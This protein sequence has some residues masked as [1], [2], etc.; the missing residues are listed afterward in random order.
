[1]CFTANGCEGLHRYAGHD[2]DSYRTEVL[3]VLAAM[4]M[5]GG[6][7]FGLDNHAAFEDVMRIISKPIAETVPRKPWSLL[8]NGDLLER[9]HV[10][11]TAKSL[12]H[13]GIMGKRALL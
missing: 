5:P 4:G 9:V 1:M 8:K 6:V 3:G 13:R 7:H 11:S 12:I 2:V 10:F